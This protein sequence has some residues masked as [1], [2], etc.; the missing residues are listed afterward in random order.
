MLKAASRLYRATYIKN[1][2]NINT[3]TETVYS[4]THSIKSG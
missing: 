1:N 4:K 3:Y 2:Y